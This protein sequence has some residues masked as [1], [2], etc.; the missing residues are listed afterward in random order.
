MG[1]NEK[2]LI[3]ETD[4]LFNLIKIYLLCPRFYENSESLQI[5][6]SKEKIEKNSL[7]QADLLSLNNKISEMKYLLSQLSDQIRKYENKYDFF[8][9]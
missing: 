8:S 6:E 2:D 3:D 7:N 4:W 5:S 9:K 1:K